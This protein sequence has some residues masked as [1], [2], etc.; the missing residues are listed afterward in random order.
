[1][2]PETQI[3]FF[4]DLLEFWIQNVEVLKILNME[5]LEAFTTNTGFA[6]MVSHGVQLETDEFICGQVMSCCSW[7]GI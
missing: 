6:R 5:T 2:F 3:A 7:F 1:L 4:L